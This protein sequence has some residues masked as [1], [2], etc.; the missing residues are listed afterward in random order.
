MK[1]FLYSSSVYSCHLFLIS[2]ASVRSIQFLSF[3][4]NKLYQPKYVAS[5]ANDIYAA[6]ILPDSWKARKSHGL[7]SGNF[8]R[9]K[10][11]ND[12]KARGIFLGEF[13]PFDLEQRWQ[14]V[15]KCSDSV[16]LL[17]S[18]YSNH[19]QVLFFSFFWRVKATCVFI[20]NFHI[21]Y[22]CLPP[23]CSLVS[24]L[25]QVKTYCLLLEACYFI[26]LSLPW[27]PFIKSLSLL[28]L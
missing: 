2:S 4:Y 12:W 21:I 3:I 25:F 17:K 5:T 1:I 9:V 27:F 26:R 13:K 8:W 24:G 10:R 15:C 11:T 6:A 28:W 20:G 23:L 18:F 16:Y 7:W 19:Q 14:F 22:I